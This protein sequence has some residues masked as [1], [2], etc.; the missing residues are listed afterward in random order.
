MLQLILCPLIQ[1][2]WGV[3]LNAKFSKS[4]ECCCTLSTAVFLLWYSMKEL[5]SKN[6]N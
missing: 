2:A 3:N 6:E 5:I 1:K 4:E